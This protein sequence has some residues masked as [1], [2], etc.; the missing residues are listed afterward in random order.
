VFGCIEIHFNKN[1]TATNKQVHETYMYAELACIGTSEIYTS[2]YRHMYISNVRH[3][4]ESTALCTILGAK[5]E[6]PKN[7]SPVMYSSNPWS[8][9]SS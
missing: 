1:R 5:I 4:V 6:S 9:I 7:K 8:F 2:I 3:V